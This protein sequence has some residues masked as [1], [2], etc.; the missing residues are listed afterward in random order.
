MWEAGA[1]PSRPLALT[2]RSLPC[3]SRRGGNL[4]NRR[5]RAPDIGADQGGIH[6]HSFFIFCGRI[7]A[8]RSS[9]FRRCAS[10]LALLVREHSRTCA[11]ACVD[12]LSP[13]G[14]GRPAEALA[15]A[16]ER[17]GGVAEKHLHI[18]LIL[19]PQPVEGW[20]DESSE[21]RKTRVFVC[22]KR[23]EALSISLIHPGF[24]HQ[25]AHLAFCKTVK[26][27]SHRASPN[28]ALNIQTWRCRPCASSQNL[29]CAD[30]C[31]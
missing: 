12:P 23:R 8:R 16:G 1:A 10:V 22:S 24:Q 2:A 30:E 27:K 21:T 7:V 11:A 13:C 9:L 14:R 20:K 15:K 31:P 25:P 17:G 6:I 29:L 3:H 18:T 5:V 4:G 28:R 26:T 19:S